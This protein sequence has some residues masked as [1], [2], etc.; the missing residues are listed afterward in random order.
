M[1]WIEDVDTIRELW[2]VI[3]ENDLARTP[4]RRSGRATQ[5]NAQEMIRNPQVKLFVSLAR[6]R[7]RA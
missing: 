2:R 4:H 6:A 3:T 5:N 7:L 1:R